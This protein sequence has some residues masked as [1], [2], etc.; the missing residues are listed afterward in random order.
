MDAPLI[1]ASLALAAALA[2][3]STDMTGETAGGF[4]L[5]WAI[6][7]AALAALAG[8][9]RLAARAVARRMRPSRPATP[10]AEGRR[11]VEAAFWIAMAVNGALWWR[12]L[13]IDRSSTGTDHYA[14]GAG[15]LVPYA[16][17]IAAA[18][19]C[20]WF[21]LVRWRPARILLACGAVGVAA[22]ALLEIAWP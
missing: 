22:W 16:V 17:E 14:M 2:H 8:A 3:L 13:A 10:R 20:Y 19:A 4:A 7:G 1:L 6:C 18:S 11:T 21:A 5:Q 12:E 15:V 9:I